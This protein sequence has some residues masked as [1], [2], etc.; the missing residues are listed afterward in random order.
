MGFMVNYVMSKII[1][2]EVTWF[3]PACILHEFTLVYLVMT[4]VTHNV[5]LVFGFP[6]K[7]LVL[8]SGPDEEVGRVTHK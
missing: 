8:L 2:V 6:K 5:V 1:P 4:Q 3:C 7:A